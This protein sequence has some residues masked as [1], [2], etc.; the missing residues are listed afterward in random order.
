MTEHG[1][2]H[3]CVHFSSISSAAG[4]SDSQIT[5]SNSCQIIFRGRSCEIMNYLLLAVLIWH[6]TS[7]NALDEG[8]KDEREVDVIFRAAGFGNS[9]SAILSVD[10]KDLTSFTVC[11]A[12]M[13][14]RLVDVTP[15]PDTAT[16]WYVLES[17]SIY[18]KFDSL[19]IDDG[20]FALYKWIHTCYSIDLV[21]DNVTLVIN[22]HEISKGKVNLETKP[23]FFNM[24]LENTRL[25]ISVT[26]LNL[27]SSALPVD[28]MRD[29]TNAESPE[30][31][32]SG[33]FLTWERALE[34]WVLTGKAERLNLLG[35][36]QR[37]S[38]LTIFALGFPSATACMEHCK[39]LGSRSP[40][41]RTL[42]EWQNLTKEIHFLTANK[43]NID[44]WLAIRFDNK[45]KDEQSSGGVWRDYYT[46]ERL[47]N[48]TKPWMKNDDGANFVTMHYTEIENG[49]WAWRW[50]RNN[51]RL[52][53]YGCPCQKAILQLRG[54]CPNSAF[55]GENEVRGLQYTPYQCSK[56][57][58][59]EQSPFDS[60]FAGG[61]S[62]K[63][64]TDTEKWKLTVANFDAFAVSQ[65]P[66]NS[67]ALGKHTW[68]I[69]NDKCHN[70]SYRTE[71]K[72]TACK[73]G[74]FTCNDG[75]CIKM[76]ERC[77]QLPDCEDRSDE[78]GCQLIV[79]NEGYNKDVAPFSYVPPCTDARILPAQVNVSIEL[80]SVMSIDEVDNSIDLKFE[81][82][83]EWFD[84]R[85][86]YKTSKRIEFS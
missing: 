82:K 26:K 49:T 27:F 13:L 17:I 83:L 76:P 21:K 58:C 14:D 15:S 75:Q 54:L 47:D 11:F 41:V 8:E 57:P 34:T 36:C 50:N 59:N 28:S 64:A 70:G 20:T 81:I 19:F 43:E 39:K 72:L 4:R 9:S 62:T 30:C 51:Y 84:H 23:K 56:L 42:Q 74:E 12:F 77:D 6:S 45:T 22:G 65:A 53:K 80:F 85:L 44:F 73:D 35:P 46:G 61:I 10:L 40:P 24:T 7:T 29:I 32:R 18:V 67:Y 5:N 48:F 2:K 55:R 1:L 38:S 66:E 69:F 25:S 33:D 3:C 71:L 86:T 79:L 60:F 37:E 68:N 16:F 78:K 63:I 31:G 52:N